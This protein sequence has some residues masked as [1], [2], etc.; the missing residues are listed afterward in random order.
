MMSTTAQ[1]PWGGA[2]LVFIR[3]IKPPGPP[4]LHEWE[5]N[6]SRNKMY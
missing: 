1:V 4:H 2:E 6:I 5:N 3:L